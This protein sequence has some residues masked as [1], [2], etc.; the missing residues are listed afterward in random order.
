[1]ISL[2]IRTL[3]EAE[4]VAVLATP[5]VVSVLVIAPD[6]MVFPTVAKAPFKV[7][8]ADGPVEPPQ[9]PAPQP[10]PTV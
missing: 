6:N 5:I 1:M 8:V 4:S 9:P 10:T 7:V 2:S 3:P